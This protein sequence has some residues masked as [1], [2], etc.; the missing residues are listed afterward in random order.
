MFCIGLKKKCDCHTR[1]VAFQE[2]SVYFRTVLAPDIQL[3]VT[4]EA[5]DVWML[6][7]SFLFIIW[8][9]YPSLS[10]PSR[11]TSQKLLTRFRQNLAE[12]C[13]LFLRMIGLRAPTAKG[14]HSKQ[15][16]SNLLSCLTQHRDF[17]VA[18]QIIRR[19]LRHTDHNQLFFWPRV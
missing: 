12:W 15:L 14:P 18:M 4:V 2:I 19:I 8:T 1:H 13:V 6:R 10:P 7:N 9:V 5:S 17:F 3:A 16:K 11:V